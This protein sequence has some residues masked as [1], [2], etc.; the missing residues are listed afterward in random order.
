MQLVVL[1]RSHQQPHLYTWVLHNMQVLLP[2]LPVVTTDKTELEDVRWFHRDWVSTALTPGSV[3]PSAVLPPSMSAP[4]QQQRT[5][6]GQQQQALQETQPARF[7]IP[8]RWS[9]AYR[10][11]N[12]W[13]SGHLAS[14]AAAAPVL[15]PAAG[16]SQP[17]VQVGEQPG[18]TPESGSASNSCARPGWAGDQ[19]PQVAIDTGG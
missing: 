9:L 14:T 1:A 11:I 2:R 12:T 3:L 17:E 16:T 15:A 5:S 13:L 19:I 4:Q 6:G 18:S 7:H 10:L 8:G